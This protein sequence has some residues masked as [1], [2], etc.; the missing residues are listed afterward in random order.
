MPSGPSWRCCTC[1]ATPSTPTPSATWATRRSPGT[2]RC[3]ELAG[4]DRDTAIALL[5]RA[6]G[7]GLLASL[8]G[9][10]YRIH[11]AL[12]WYFT[13]LFT[14]TY[15][16]PG[17]PAAAQRA[18]RAYT[19]AIGALGDYYHDQVGDGPRGPGLPALRAEEANLRHALTLA[20]ARRAVGRRGRLPAGPAHPV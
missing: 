11:P 17:S 14:A 1:S 19:R 18:A 9:G 7:I 12:P 4:L 20:R 5:D 15:G 3:P 16:P 2:T 8:G 10:Y 13:T 6:A